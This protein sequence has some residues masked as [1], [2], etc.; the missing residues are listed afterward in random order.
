[1]T[2]FARSSTALHPSNEA[3]HIAAGFDP[4]GARRLALA[5][6]ARAGMDLQSLA[7]LLKRPHAMPRPHHLDALAWLLDTRAVT[8]RSLR[9]CCDL[10]DHCAENYR[11]HAVAMV[12]R[13]ALR[14]R[15][16]AA[17]GRN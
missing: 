14:D 12:D 7:E 2:Y 6:L 10:A 11:A 17:D 13:N 15:L 1:M 5:M 4:S 8:P 3:R 9:W 16:A